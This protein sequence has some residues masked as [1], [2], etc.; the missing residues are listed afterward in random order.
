MVAGILFFIACGLHVLHQRDQSEAT[1]QGEKVSLIARF[2]RLP[3]T[4]LFGSFFCFFVALMFALVLLMASAKAQDKGEP[5]SLH[6][7]EVHRTQEDTEFG[8]VYHI[9]AVVE[10]KTV[11]Y[12]LKCDESY[13]NKSGYNG[14]CA[15]LS[16]G[17]DYSARKSENDINF[18]QAE[19]RDKGYLLILYQIVSEKEK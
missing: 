10:S 14:R 18:W 1:Y 7:K 15:P 13:L 19:D 9:T 2:L 6:V 4:S 16:A 17:K 3:W 5:I 8:A 12:S 11:V